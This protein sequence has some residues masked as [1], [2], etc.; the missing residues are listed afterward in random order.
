MIL[1]YYF[2]L[3]NIFNIAKSLYKI[4]FKDFDNNK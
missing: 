2:R 1:S 3:I 4:K